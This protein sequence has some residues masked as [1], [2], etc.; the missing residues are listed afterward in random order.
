MPRKGMFFQVERVTTEHESGWETSIS[1]SWR[2]ARDEP[3][4][5]YE[6]SNADGFDVEAGKP[7]K[8]RVKVS[9]DHKRLSFAAASTATPTFWGPDQPITGVNVVGTVVCPSS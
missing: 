1:G 8:I 6:G 4:S 2:S 7:T 5:L 9:P 3:F